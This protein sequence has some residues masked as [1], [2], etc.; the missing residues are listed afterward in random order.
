MPSVQEASA[1]KL[2]LVMWLP[3]PATQTADLDS[4]SACAGAPLLG[5][6]TADYLAEGILGHAC[7]LLLHCNRL[8]A[9]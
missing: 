4:T 5:L 9:G 8:H 1:Q 6:T 7:G 3:M 2:M